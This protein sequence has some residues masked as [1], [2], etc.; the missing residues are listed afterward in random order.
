VRGA[1]P[2][3][4]AASCWAVCPKLSKGERWATPKEKLDAN[5]APILEVDEGLRVH[6]VLINPGAFTL[7]VEL[8]RAEFGL[9]VI[10]RETEQLRGLVLFTEDKAG[11]DMKDGDR[12]GEND[13]NH[14]YDSGHDPH[15]AQRTPPRQ[16]P[17]LGRRVLPKRVRRPLARRAL[18]AR[19]LAHGG[20]GGRDPRPSA[21]GTSGRVGSINDRVTPA[22]A[23]CD[24]AAREAAEGAARTRSPPHTRAPA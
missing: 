15:A 11:S 17:D 3:R 10:T 4:N 22:C 16:P 19:R 14:H 6:A 1:S 9:H 18:Q 12:N 8:R 20:V 7:C 13:C 23:F 21:T 5:H 24:H 2:R